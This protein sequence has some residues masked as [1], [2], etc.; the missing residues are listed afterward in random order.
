MN[1]E[2]GGRM[3]QGPGDETETP[4]HG[5]PGNSKR[6]LIAGW[7]VAIV[8]MLLWT[9]ALFIDGG[10]PV[11]EWASFSPSWISEMLPN[12]QA[13]LGLVISFAGMG[14]IY[15]VQIQQLRGRA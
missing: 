3:E 2:H 11:I 14:P 8:G 15:Y 1:E 9:Y 5:G 13:E 12:W 10:A 4:T 7:A 6:L